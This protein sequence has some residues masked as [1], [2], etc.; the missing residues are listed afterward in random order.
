MLV[1]KMIYSKDIDLSVDLQE[2]K[3]LL[4]HKNINIGFVESED[5][6]NC[7]IKII[8]DEKSNDYLEKEN[9]IKM[10]ISNVLYKLV[11]KQY[12]EKELYQILSEDFF[13][14]KQDEIL[15]VEEAVL[16]TLNLQ[17]FI[18]EDLFVFCSNKV[19]DILEKIR[20]CIDENNEINI[21]G[22]L[23][24]RTKQYREDIE[25]IV[26]KV[27]EKYMVDKEYKEFIKLLKYFVDIQESKIDK[28]FL[29]VQ[30]Q[31]GYILKDELGKDMLNVFLNELNDCKIGVDA[32]LE[33]VIISGLITSVPKKIMIYG[34]EACSNKEF[35]ETIIKVFGNRVII[36]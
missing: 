12:K 8:Y 19:N 32:N 31:G 18:C 14:L 4:K 27:V 20:E 2:L 6:S 28:V 26:E 15:K 25:D 17:K 1:L 3:A 30:P 22:F 34:K 10:Y 11:L 9:I 29:Y 16:N 7:S 24:F 13:F 35:I 23:T 33:D 36:C 5:G 21:N